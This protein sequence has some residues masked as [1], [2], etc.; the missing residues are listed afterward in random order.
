MLVRFVVKNFLSFKE[1]TEFN[2]LPGRAQRLKHHKYKIDGLELLKLSALYGANGSGKSNL[3]KAIATLKEMLVTGRIPSVLTK[4]WF[5]LDAA[6]KDQPSEMAIE[7]YCNTAFYYYS[8]SILNNVVADE[9]FAE[10]KGPDKDD[11]LIYHRTGNGQQ[12]VEFFKEFYENTENAVLASVIVKDLMKPDVPLFSLL[13]GLSNDAFN[14]VRYALD[15]FETNLQLIFPTTSAVYLAHEVDLNPGFRTFANELMRAFNTGVI[16]L[17]VDKKP[18][19]DFLGSDDPKRLE[20][21]RSILNVPGKMLVLQPNLADEQHIAV[22]NEGGKIFAKQLCFEHKDNEGNPVT[23]SYKE[24]SDGTRRLLEYLPALKWLV[25]QKPGLTFII[26]EIER[27]IHPLM[28][29]EILA[30]FAGDANTQGQLVFSTHDT[31]LLDQEIFRPDEIWFA[32]KDSFGATHLYPLSDF[33]EHSTIDIRKGYLNGRYG[34][35]P[36][37]GNLEDLNWNNVTDAKQE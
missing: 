26:D 34:A 10:V 11:I 7:F 28:I 36:F 19:E 5:K 12:N 18:I 23:F 32:E 8:I 33:K 22:A 24:E 16:E 20:E 4:S 30:K 2:L 31:N 15:W 37:L 17:K 27:S 3:V 35:I 1:Q 29:K 14:E 13:R 25:A 9:Y 21:I 6:C